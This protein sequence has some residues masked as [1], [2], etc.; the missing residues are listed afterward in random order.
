MTAFFFSHVT[1]ACTVSLFTVARVHGTYRC[2]MVNV[3]STRAACRPLHVLHSL[4]LPVFT[5]CIS[6]IACSEQAMTAG[7]IASFTFAN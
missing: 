4:H 6:V 3:V 2:R 5:P 1:S 7:D